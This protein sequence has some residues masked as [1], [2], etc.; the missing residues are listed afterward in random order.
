MTAKE[1]MEADPLRQ[2]SDKLGNF[3]RRPMPKED[4]YYKAETLSRKLDDDFLK[5]QSP[6]VLQDLSTKAY[7]PTPE[8]AQEAAAATRKGFGVNPTTGQKPEPST[9][10]LEDAEK[11]FQESVFGSPETGG[12]PTPKA[13]YTASRP[14]GTTYKAPPEPKARE[15][16]AKPRP[17]GS[18]QKAYEEEIARKLKERE[19]DGP[20]LNDKD[21]RTVNGWFFFISG[22][23]L[24]LWTRDTTTPL[25]P[26]ATASELDKL[27]PLQVKEL[28]RKKVEE[29]QKA[30]E[31]NEWDGET[32]PSRH[33]YVPR[34]RSLIATR[35]GPACNG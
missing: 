26:T 7:P 14:A 35:N 20:I 12:S 25:Y 32:I 18:S 30:P 1:R 28:G 11:R 23:S 31:H 5:P 22:F 21:L 3:G 8:S 13:A 17:L 19:F 4:A 27:D 2:M 33:I 29:I 9:G 34:N 24:W 10:P 16:V 6:F 15:R